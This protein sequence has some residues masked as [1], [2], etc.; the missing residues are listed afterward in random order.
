MMQSIVNSGIS[1]GVKRWIT[2]LQK[3]CEFTALLT[4][5]A[6]F[7]QDLSSK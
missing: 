4:A 7:P 3:Y 1:F 6:N 2:T 5:S